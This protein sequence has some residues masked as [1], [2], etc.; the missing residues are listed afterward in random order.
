MQRFLAFIDMHTTSLLL[1]A[2]SFVICISSVL[3][4][5]FRFPYQSAKKHGFTI[6]SIVLIIAII[7]AIELYAH[8]GELQ[9][10]I[11]IA[12]NILSGSI[13]AILC[14]IFLG[15][16]KRIKNQAED[17]EKLRQDYEVLSQKYKQNNLVEA[18]NQNGS[19]VTYPVI[20]LGTGFILLN[21]DGNKQITISDS[22]DDYY[23]L[24]TIIENHY[25]DIFSIHDT[26][27]I[28]NN[29]NIRVNSMVLKNNQLELSTMRTTYYDS[30]VTNRA[31]DFN[32]SEGISVRELFETGPRMTPLEKSRLSNHLGYNGFI[33]SRDG[34]IVFVKRSRDLSIGKR[35]YGDSIGAS[36]KAKYALDENG[37]FTYQ[38]LRTSIIKEIYDELKI[39]IEDIDL[40]TLSIIAAYRDCVECGKPQLLIFARSSKTACE[41]SADFARSCQKKMATTKK[42]DAKR[43]KELEALVDGTKLLWVHK[44]SLLNNIIFYPDR[45]EIKKALGGEGFVSFHE[46]GKKPSAIHSL[47]MVPSASASV[48]LFKEV[49]M[50]PKII[51]S[52][53]SSKYED[54][55]LCED[56]LI[57]NSNVIAV[58][59]GV[60]AKSTYKWNGKSSGRYAMEIIEKA[61]EKG[62]STQSP[63]AFF[64]ALNQILRHAVQQHPECSI[65]D[66]PRASVIAYVVG[67]QE[68]WSY[69]DC[70]CIVGDEYFSHEKK[71]DIALSNKRAAII[72]ERLAD[73]NTYFDL[74][75][76]DFGREAIMDDLMH[77]FKYENVHYL[78]DGCDYGYP[79]LNGGD[80]CEDMITVHKVPKGA[81]T[82]LASDGY[83]VLK[84]TLRDSEV[85]LERII[86]CDPLCFKVYKSTKGLSP[87]CVSFDD[88]TYIRFEI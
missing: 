31:A 85:E 5:R 81:M 38:G 50:L 64:S 26:S 78:V 34:Y 3:V 54:Q 21:K 4:M 2:I 52:F 55:A 51:E 47:K 12:D 71:I 20:N 8:F 65:E 70:R 80:I 41:I 25:M 42:L 19:V 9:S 39:D 63:L 18:V 75:Q 62:V 46:S 48:Y 16:E 82:V 83:P 7:Y 68:I 44:D 79:V 88:R 57:I 29:L 56:G 69:G 72:E 87:E 36:L 58:I 30:L 37:L 45:I 28:Y 11:N 61:L 84:R 17:A 59:D 22:P 74:Q 76:H 49:L 32:L 6:A 73:S 60:T 33:E 14:V 67:K 40:D 13:F 43:R 27:N 15:F 10:W 77:Q 24:P 23:K 1:I 66:R 35:T 53:I 86:K